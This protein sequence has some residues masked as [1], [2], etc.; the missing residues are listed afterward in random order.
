MQN[1]SKRKYPKIKESFIDKLKK[2]IVNMSAPRLIVLSFVI[3]IFFGTLFLSLPISSRD[4]EWTSIFD[5]FFAS[6]SCVCVTGIIP[7]DTYCKYSLF[8][9]FINILL[10]QLGG[11]SLIVLTSGFILLF[12]GKMGVRHIIIAQQYTSGNITDMYNLIKYILIFASFFEGIG[13]LILAIKFVPEYGFYGI[14]IS[15]FTS[16]SAFCNAGEV[17]F[18]FIEPFAN[19]NMYY[20]DPLVNI[21]VSVLVIAGGIGF[22]VM[23][24]LYTCL[25]NKIKGIERHPKLSLNTKV[26]LVFTAVLLVTGTIIFYILENK[27]TLS[28]MS[29]SDK[30]LVSFFNMMSTR[31]AGFFTIYPD[32]L[33]KSTK[34]LMC[35]FMFIGAGPSS[36]ASGIKIT[37][38]ITILCTMTSVL[39]G[40]EDTIIMNRKINKQTVYRSTA[41]LLT[42]ILVA[43]I[44]CILIGLM[45]YDKVHNIMDIIFD[46][47]SCLSTCG[48]STGATAA[49]SRISKII[50]MMIMF[51]GRV[52]PISLIFAIA[53]NQEKKI[54]SVIPE[55]KI[56]VG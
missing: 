25:C 50:L 46:V 1:N 52:G 43:V 10:I 11:L 5:A 8:G 27:N 3:I 41:I 56:I 38:L 17:L 44:G 34:I 22:L 37:T 51:F 20:N 45:E 13:S 4:R 15:L 26:V 9:Q 21:V 55:G 33:L 39:R 23:M 18:G 14:W 36:T 40:Y 49:F 24:E 7:V 2:Y 53:L 42:Y 31:T 6:V 16:I 12:K 28:G 54:K 48:L 47:I 35:V 29:I 32:R 30:I 19:M